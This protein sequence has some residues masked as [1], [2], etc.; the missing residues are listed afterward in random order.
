MKYLVT[1][2]L[3]DGTEATYSV[4]ATNRADAEYRAADKAEEQGKR[5]SHVIACRK[6][7]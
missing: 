5:V 2:R 1:L 3:Q 4:I 6:E 7:Y